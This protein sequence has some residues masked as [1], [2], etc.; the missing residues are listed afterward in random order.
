MATA[1]FNP[2]NVMSTYF[3]PPQNIIQ[4]GTAT[5]GST[6]QG[7]LETE[8]LLSHWDN[9]SSMPTNC[10]I[11]DVQV[12]VNCRLVSGP[13]PTINIKF[14]LNP[15][16]LNS[17]VT[18][19]SLSDLTFGGTTDSTQTWGGFF[20]SR[21][22]LYQGGLNVLTIWLTNS[23]GSVVEIDYVTVTVT[24][25]TSSTYLLGS[26]SFFNG[27]E[28]GFL[29][30]IPLVSNGN[31]VS[32]LVASEQVNR[33]GDCL[34]NIERIALS[35]NNFFSIGP[36]K[37]GNQFLYVTT[38]TFPHTYVASMP[39]SVCYEICKFAIAADSMG[40]STSKLNIPSSLTAVTP[41]GTSINNKV[42]LDFVSA[43][44]WV[45]VSGTINPLHVSP[46]TMYFGG[47]NG[48]TF[49]NPEY[50][51]SFTAINPNIQV[52]E[53]NFTYQNSKLKTFRSNSFATIP[54][55]SVTIKITAIGGE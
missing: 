1:T 10:M 36:E 50:F 43:I 17:T 15:N 26:R 41:N 5:S 21:D 28:L 33:L 20:N 7:Y 34:V 2:T 44:G 37:G 51:L 11:A 3:T 29:D 18:S 31:T 32:N 12:T 23:V 46:K 49:T 38:L 19:G 45:D 42:K 39:K 9:A 35:T 6:L 13:T 16:T 4:T 47:T 53:A 27:T 48:L 40:A 52:S 8:I 25:V 24:Y 30:R 22:F 55:G 14:Q 54:N